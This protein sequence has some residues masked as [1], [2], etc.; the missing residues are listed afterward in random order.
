MTLG[1]IL[2]IGEEAGFGTE[3][4]TVF[5]ANLDIAGEYTYYCA[6]YG[7]DEGAGWYNED[8]ALCNSLQLG[9]NGMGVQIETQGATIQFAGSVAK[10]TVEIKG[11]T[12]G[13]SYVCNPTP[14][15]Q[16]LQNFVVIGD[17]AGFGT[18]L[19]TTFDEN[20]DIS[21]EYTYYCADYGMDAGAGWYNEDGER[22]DVTIPSAS[23]FIFEC[24]GGVS[25]E[26][27]AVLAD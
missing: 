3:L 6:D 25:I 24:Q 10:G 21:G 7:M 22:V 16:K 26:L 13:F 8:G 5:D 20:L 2:P 15:D 4:V 9:G 14:I 17:D 23:G 11:M 1:D 19:I 12:P 27:P 18:E